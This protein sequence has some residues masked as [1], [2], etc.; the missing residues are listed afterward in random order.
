[1]ISAC[2][3]AGGESSRVGQP[4]A[5]LK[6][7]T[8]NF[9]ERISENLWRAGIKDISLVLGAGAPDI[10]SQLKPLREKVLVN[11]SWPG[12]Q[13]TSLQCAVRNL[14]YKYDALMVCLVDSPLVRAE[15]YE[16]LACAWQ[17]RQGSIV[18][19]SHNGKHGHP[20]IFD[21]RF[22]SEIMVAPQNEGAHWVTHRN[23]AAVFDVDTDDAGTV[24][25]VDTMEDYEK[26]VKWT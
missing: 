23:A 13:L 22:F 5:L 1:M 20:V 25:D 12:G 4:K 24:F 10:W 18:I 16:T 9:V 17:S 19:P 21:Q 15:T 14:S 2:I 8:Q 3:L 26:A 6:L 11:H 7:G